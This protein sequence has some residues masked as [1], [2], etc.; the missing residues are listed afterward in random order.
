MLKLQNT[1][2]KLGMTICSIGIINLSFWSFLNLSYAP[3]YAHAT[4][5]TKTIDDI[6]YMQEMS[7]H[8]CES[9]KESTATVDNQKRLIDHRDGKSYWVAKFKDGRCWM[10][11]NLD[12]GLWK[13]DNE[14]GS[15]SILTSADS[16]II[17][18]WTSTTG[19]STLWTGSLDNPNIIKYYDPGNKYCTNNRTDK[20]DLITSNNN[21]HDSQGNYYSWGAATVGTTSNMNNDGDITSSSICPKGWKLPLSGARYSNGIYS[22]DTVSGSFKYLMT[23]QGIT[24]DD[25][26]ASSALL[27]APLY[28]IYS[29]YVTDNLLGGV[30]SGGHYW[31]STVTNT[32][33]I[34]SLVFIGSSA[35]PSN[36]S[37]RFSGHSIRCVNSDTFY[38]W[39]APEEDNANINVTI[40]TILTVEA[41]SNVDPNITPNNITDGTITATVSS[42]TEYNIFL[43]ADQPNLINSKN[44]EGPNIPANINVSPNTN[45]WA[46]KDD[47]TGNTYKAIKTA[48]DTFYNTK[49][50]DTLGNDIYTYGLGISIAP[51]LPAGTYSTTVTITASTK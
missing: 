8:V 25:A 50:T 1:K 15:G 7:P 10:T 31:S 12:L 33:S 20:C 35:N 39:Q 34:Y 19:A 6:K 36:N 30:G 51:S 5:D 49:T 26:A 18:D 46:I 24:T 23:H 3:K 37:I 13:G 14:T 44:P 2:H 47:S 4:E 11:Q 21:G 28:F 40:P 32:I 42:N 45:A 17:S 16:D 29:G 9:M 48:T 22:N 41:S 43:S 38:D 27:S